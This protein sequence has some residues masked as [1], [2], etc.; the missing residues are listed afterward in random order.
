M[1]FEA[2]ATDSQSGGGAVACHQ[3]NVCNCFRVME[4]LFVFI[5]VTLLCF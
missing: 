2:A 1:T 3:K 5:S 4:Q